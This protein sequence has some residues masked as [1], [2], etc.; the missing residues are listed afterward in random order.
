[1]FLPFRDHN[2]TKHFPIVT[3][4]LIALNIVIFGYML[5]LQDENYDSFAAFVMQ[6][7]FVPRDL[8]KISL[9]LNEDFRILGTMFTSMF[10]HGSFSHIIGNMLFLSIFG[11]NIEDIM[12][13]VKFIIFYCI[14][15]I[16]A[17][18]AQG[19]PSLGNSSAD[20]PM[21][22][23]SGA[24][25]GILGAYL[26]KFPF[27][28]VDT[29]VIF[30]LVRLPAFLVLISW[31]FVQLIHLG[32]LNIEQSGTAYYAHV[33]G[34]ICGMLLVNSFVNKPKRRKKNRD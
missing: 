6:Y 32:Q 27:A 9:N 15:G 14:C 4:S 8:T 13:P 11:N 19:I 17:C 18:L 1:M 5:L 22:G 31:F 24:I 12:G 23:A 10:L 16:I 3:I 34:F 26:I 25:S 2:P 7:A 30:I 21:L 28:K 33:G 20:I 29:C